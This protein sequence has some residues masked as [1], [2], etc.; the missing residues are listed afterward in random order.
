V[1]GGS[2]VRQ[3]LHADVYRL[4]SLAEIEDLGLGELSRTRLW[5]SS[6]GA[7][8]PGRSSARA[9]CSSSS[10]R[11]THPSDP[12]DPATGSEGHERAPHSEDHA[13]DDAWAGRLA[14]LGAEGPAVVVEAAP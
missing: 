2:G 1:T 3:L 11:R 14:E 12:G 10:R 9:P 6:S 4:E 8:G 5:H 13:V 7:S